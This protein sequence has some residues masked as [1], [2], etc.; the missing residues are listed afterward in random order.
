MRR[1]VSAQLSACILAI[2]LPALCCAST[3]QSCSTL[4][5]VLNA[6][7]RWWHMQQ[8]FLSHNGAPLWPGQM[9]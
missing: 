1:A 9:R 6:F 2:L 7:L 4:F 8:M 3:G 5:G